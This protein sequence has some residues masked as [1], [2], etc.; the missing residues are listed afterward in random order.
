MVVVFVIFNV[1]T[2]DTFQSVAF[3]FMWYHSAPF[4]YSQPQIIL[5]TV[6]E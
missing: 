2:G 5:Y 6:S 1:Q 3:K 4:A